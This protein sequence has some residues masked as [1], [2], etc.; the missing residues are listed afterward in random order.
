M[1]EKTVL[2]PRTIAIDED[3]VHCSQGCNHWVR[4][5]RGV[6]VCLMFNRSIKHLGSL[7]ERT[8][9][10]LAAKEVEG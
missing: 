2:I 7:P 5:S 9:A 3:G 8:P 4:A 10:C 6:S 1:I